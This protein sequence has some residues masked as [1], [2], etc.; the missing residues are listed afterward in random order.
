MNR[1]VPRLESLCASASSFL[2]SLADASVDV[3]TDIFSS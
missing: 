2:N 1:A 3:A